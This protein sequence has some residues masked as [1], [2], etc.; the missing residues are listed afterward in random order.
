MDQVFIERAQYKGGVVATKVIRKQRLKLDR[1][2]LLEMRNMTNVKSMY[3]ATFIGATIEPPLTEVW[4]YY[5]KGGLQDVLWNDNMKLDDMFKYS[6]GNDVLKGLIYIHSGP[7][8]VHGRLKSTNVVVDGR[9]TC[10]L[11]DYGL[12]TLRDGQQDDPELSD[13]HRYSSLYW[14]APELMTSTSKDGFPTVQSKTVA[15][16]IYAAA[17]I[18]KEVF[19]RN[20]PYSEYDDLSPIDIIEKVRSPVQTNCEPFRPSLSEISVQQSSEVKEAIIKG[21]AQ[22]PLARPS[23]QAMQTELQKINPNKSSNVADNM[24]KMM[25]RY[26]NNL[27]EL[28]AER[29]QQVEEEKKKSEHLLY[30]MLPK[31]VADNLKAGV[32]LEAED[33]D[34][35]TIYFSDIVKFTN[36]SAESTPMQVV[37][38]LNK[39]YTIWDAIIANHDVYKVETIGDAYMVVSGVPER[40]RD[41]HA[42]EIANT[43]L[44]LLSGIMD[45]KVPHKPDYQ[46]RIRI[47]LHTGSVVAGVVGQAMPRYC[48]F[49]SAVNTAAMF[50]AGGSPMRIHISEP[51]YKLL[52]K[53]HGYQIADRGSDLD[54]KGG[55][56]LHSYWLIG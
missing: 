7:L 5:T 21:W 16:D 12:E 11:T 51:T 14:T 37:E 27:E 15:G 46:L 9:W 54:C 47:G 4:E 53:F 3:M 2:L 41:N 13:H 34:A 52:C 39:L 25:E 18:L 35:V 10:K 49:G 20:E 22:N 50:E 44:D 28:V 43:A 33:Y 8:K 31:T 55:V 38:L 24:A 56:K 45:F 17:V 30:R 1:K 23:A 40:N 36:L 32:P 42:P 48:L 6:I 29:T 19:A 26:S